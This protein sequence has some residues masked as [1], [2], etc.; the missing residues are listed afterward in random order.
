MMH[1]ATFYTR[2]ECHLCEQARE[3]IDRCKKRLS[4][5]IETVDV[6]ENLEARKLYGER[7]PVLAIENGPVLEAWINEESLILAMRDLGQN[8]ATSGA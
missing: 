5:Q 6:D 1:H 4:L 7:V 2:K 8:T 3:A